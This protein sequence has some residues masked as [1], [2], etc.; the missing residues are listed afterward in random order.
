MNLKKIID[1]TEIE[2]RII[3]LSNQ[4]NTMF[5]NQSIIV[6]YIE[7]G[8]KPFFEKLSKFFKFDYKYESIG[9]K[10]YDHDKSTELKWLKKPTLDVKGKV[11]MIVDDILDTGQTLSKVKDYIVSLGAKDVYTCVAID[12]KENRILK[13]IEPNF[14]LF[15][16]QSGFLVGFGMDYNE[17][18]RDLEDIYEITI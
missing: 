4:I 13:N 7:K 18:Y 8:A 9:V 3:E 1:K 5:Q 16:I 14:K 6:F 11:C 10:S 15:T 17:H 2:H 12:K